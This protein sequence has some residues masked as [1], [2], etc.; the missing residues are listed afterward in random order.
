MKATKGLSSKQIA[1]MVTDQ[2]IKGLEEGHIPWHKPWLSNASGYQN[3]AT[4]HQYSGINTLLLNLICAQRKYTYPLFA[5]FKQIS[6]LGGRV[7]KGA[8]GSSIVFSKRI[9]V[10]DKE[11]PDQKKQF[12]L[13]KSWTVFNLSQTNLDT[14]DRRISKYTT[15][16][17]PKPFDIIADAEAI[18]KNSHA[19]ILTGGDVASY[20]QMTD[21]I[22]LPDR[23]SFDTERDY[24]NTAFHELVHWTGHSSRLDRLT[25]TGFGSGEYSQEELVAEIGSNMIA[26]T[27]RMTEEI[28]RNSQAYINHWLS[29]LK[30]NNPS[31]II[32]A[33]SKA[34]KA[35]A[36]AVRGS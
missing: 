20:S 15:E 9:E 23:Q 3:F 19:S 33:S 10:E 4:G 25:K 28:T 36:M 11:N 12:S 16:T 24:Y 34:E 27:I 1:G 6:T 22:N 18:I 2:V 13:L 26:F 32:Q 29:V 5:S 8:K 21:T 30:T 14:K 17:K 7:N 31:F 35:T